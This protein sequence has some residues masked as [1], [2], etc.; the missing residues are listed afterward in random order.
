MLAGVQDKHW[1]LSIFV[2]DLTMVGK[3]GHTDPMWKFIGKEV[4][5][6]DS[7]PHLGQGKFG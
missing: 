7:R 1:F 2:D 5:L 3:I 4:D 6:E